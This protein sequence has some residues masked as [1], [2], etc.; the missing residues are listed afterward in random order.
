[1]AL[2]RYY[3]LL[4]HGKGEE[5]AK[6]ILKAKE[7]RLGAEAKEMVRLEAHKRKHLEE[8]RDIVFQQELVKAIDESKKSIRDKW[9]AQNPT[10]PLPSPIG[11]G[12]LADVVTWGRRFGPARKWCRRLC[13]R[14]RLPSLPPSG[15][16]PRLRSWL[17]SLPARLRCPR[18]TARVQGAA[19]Q[20]RPDGRPPRAATA[21][22]TGATNSRHAPLPYSESEVLARPFLL[23]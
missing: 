5:E 17:R 20:V 15:R 3:E 8:E 19:A 6:R 7:A 22:G 21:S 4:S 18:I 9:A 2:G 10:I 12:S 13:V 14:P 23:A 1:M 16:R 11:I